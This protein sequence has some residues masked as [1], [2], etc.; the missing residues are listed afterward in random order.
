MMD[1]TL[2]IVMLSASILLGALGLWALL[3]GLKTGQ[4][5]DKEK[6]LGGVLDDSE[7]TLQDAIKMENRKKEIL[8]KREQHKRDD[9]YRPLD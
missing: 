4:F 7:E 6:F 8:A 1:S 5:E 3:W 9:G 2:I